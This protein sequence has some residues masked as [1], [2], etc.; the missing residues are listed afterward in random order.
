MGRGV[1]GLKAELVAGLETWW[2]SG[3]HVRAH[4]NTAA[5]AARFVRLGVERARGKGR[6][7][8]E[9]S[10]SFVASLRTSWPDR[11]GR[12]R[13]TT[14]TARPRVIPGLRPVGH[15]RLT[16][17]NSTESTIPVTE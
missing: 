13:C 9:G 3:E 5:M 12:S 16:K 15:S 10:V 2:H 1:E 14:A 6:G 11:W 8:S 4:R 7:V 17:L